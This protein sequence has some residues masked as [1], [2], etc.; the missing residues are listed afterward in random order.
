MD[1]LFTKLSAVVQHKEPQRNSVESLK[2]WSA[3]NFPE[4]N[5]VL[6]GIDVDDL[7]SI[8]TPKGQI[9]KLVLNLSQKRIG[10]ALL[11]SGN[12]TFDRNCD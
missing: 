1:D 7:R 9:D 4:W 10:N 12:L 6:K 3:G 11:V 2:A 5:N 8:W